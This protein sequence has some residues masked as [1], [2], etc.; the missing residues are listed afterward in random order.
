MTALSPSIFYVG[1]LLPP[2]SAR[3]LFR[4]REKLAHAASHFV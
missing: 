2:S 4:T 1:F 3:K